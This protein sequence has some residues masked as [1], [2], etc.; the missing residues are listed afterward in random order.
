[1]TR[2][3]EFGQDLGLTF[4]FKPPAVAT[5]LSGSLIFALRDYYIENKKPYWSFS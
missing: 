1:M 5:I 4:F 2:Y 3:L